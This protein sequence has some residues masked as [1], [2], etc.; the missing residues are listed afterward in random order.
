MRSRRGRSQKGGRWD[1]EDG[2][3]WGP[4]VRE[5]NAEL[6]DR[7]QGGRKK[8]ISRL[9]RERIQEKIRWRPRTATRSVWGKEVEAPAGDERPQAA[10]GARSSFTPGSLRR[11]GRHTPITGERRPMGSLSREPQ[12]ISAE[13]AL[14]PMGGALGDPASGIHR[15]AFELTLPT[16]VPVPGL[17][18]RST[19][20]GPQGAEV[21]SLA[22]RRGW[23][24]GYWTQRPST[25]AA[26]PH[27]P[28]RG[29]CS[30]GRRAPLLRLVSQ[31][32]AGWGCQTVGPLPLGSG[33]RRARKL[34]LLPRGR[35]DTPAGRD[36]SP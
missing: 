10:A 17:R 7:S 6:R 31:V 15:E 9:R 32:I 22:G 29:C 12:P 1:A 34:R 11:P 28:V 8:K 23:T 21:L 26:V 20:R 16:P 36:R 19:G 5:G 14:R 4:G 27:L 33:A 24:L 13:P 18:T 2:R 30:C 25:E 3:L 35:W